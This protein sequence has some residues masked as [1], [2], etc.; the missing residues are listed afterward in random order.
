MEQDLSQKTEDQIIALSDAMKT[1]TMQHARAMPGQPLVKFARLVAAGGAVQVGDPA[2][3]L[4]EIEGL[5]EAFDEQ[6][7]I[8]SIDLEVTVGLALLQ[9]GQPREAIEQLLVVD[10]LEGVPTNY[11]D[12]TLSLAQVAVGDL[13]GARE[14]VDRV[15]ADDRGTYLDRRTALLAAAM[16]EVRRGDLGAAAAR[17]DDA[18]A[19]ADG[20]ESRMSQ[21]VVRLAQAIGHEAM[22]SAAGPELRL[23]AER[24]LSEI[25]VHPLGWERAFELAAGVE[26]VPAM[27]TTGD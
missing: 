23:D 12:S 18:V 9:M 5:G 7:I 20:T 24:A 17:F 1:G 15:L 4:G 27:P 6:R 19:M 14:S 21:A 2:A 8:G 11:L 16:I 3:A 22:G 13:I 25:G 10:T 26:S